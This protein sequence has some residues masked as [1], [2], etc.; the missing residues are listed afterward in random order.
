[1]CLSMHLF[2]LS[3]TLFSEI[4]HNGCSLFNGIPSGRNSGSKVSF[5][6]MNRHSNKIFSMAIFMF[7]SI[8]H[9][10]MFVVV[11]FF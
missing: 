1:M 11:F 5:L 10:I 2:P 4:E 3:P 6:Y 9:A 8:C 7:S